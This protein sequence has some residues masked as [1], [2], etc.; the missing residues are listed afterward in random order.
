MKEIVLRDTR[1]L[2]TIV[3]KVQLRALE[4]AS[5]AL[6]R[7]G[8]EDY[9]GSGDVPWAERS[10]RVAV[11]VML[12][13]KAADHARETDVG[14]RQFGLLVMRERFKDARSWEDHAAEVD[15]APPPSAVI[16]V[17]EAK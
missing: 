12:A 13:A 8:D 16:D 7:Q 6:L 5:R 15:G 2:A 3:A 17:P 9:D 1:E 10:T 14:N 4:A 11:G